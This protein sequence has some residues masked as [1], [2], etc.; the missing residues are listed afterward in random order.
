MGTKKRKKK[1][2]STKW[3]KLGA[4]GSEKRKAWMKHIR[5]MR[6]KSKKKTSGDC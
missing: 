1:S 4:P 5:G 2:T 6:G 3:G